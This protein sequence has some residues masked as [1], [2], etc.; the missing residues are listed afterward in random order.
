LLGVA[1]DPTTNFVSDRVVVVLSG[2]HIVDLSGV[3]REVAAIL[4]FRSTGRVIEIVRCG[5]AIVAYPP[6][7]CYTND[8]RW[9]TFKQ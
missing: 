5:L 6:V 2:P 9:A 8:E 7:D 4:H 1:R 3:L